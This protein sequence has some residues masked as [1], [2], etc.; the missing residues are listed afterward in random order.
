MSV[1]NRMSEELRS[2]HC[3]LGNLEYPFV[4]VI[5]SEVAH[6]S[7]AKKRHQFFDLVVGGCFIERNS[8]SMRTEGAEI[9]SDPLRPF[10]QVATQCLAELNPNRVEKILVRDF[11]TELAQT[12][13]QLGSGAMNPLSDRAQPSWAVRNRVHG[14]DNAQE[15]LRR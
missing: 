3:E 12:L 14:R 7:S 9:H 6:V 11:K 2:A 8:Y 1:E 4:E 5:V 15:D 13:G 10:D